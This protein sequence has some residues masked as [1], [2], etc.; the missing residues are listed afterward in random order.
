MFIDHEEYFRKGILLSEAKKDD[1]FLPLYYELL[2][3][4]YFYVN[5]DYI[6]AE[7]NYEKAL[8]VNVSRQNSNRDLF[9][10]MGK[11]HENDNKCDDRGNEISIRFYLKALRMPESGIE[12]MYDTTLKEYVA[13]YV[14]NNKKCD[15]KT[16]FNSYIKKYEYD[17]GEAEKFNSILES[18]PFGTSL[19]DYSIKLADALDKYSNY[20]EMKDP[21]ISDKHLSNCDRLA[22]VYEALGQYEKAYKL[23]LYMEEKSPYFCGYHNTCNRA[24]K[25]MK[26]IEREK[27]VK[28]QILILYSNPDIFK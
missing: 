15:Y 23:L 11:C 13:E 26:I 14:K 21:M 7:K 16:I 18:I 22:Y 4:F 17:Y 6:N 5:R 10:K 2:G 24:L 12:C 8:N 25:L 9:I 27:F 3:D 28:S 20:V 19:R 1:S